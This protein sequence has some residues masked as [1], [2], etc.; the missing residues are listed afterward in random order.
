VSGGLK[1]RSKDR[2]GFTVGMVAAAD[3]E[4]IHEMP[5]SVLCECRVRHPG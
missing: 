1:E 2:C 3:E 4:E 5:L